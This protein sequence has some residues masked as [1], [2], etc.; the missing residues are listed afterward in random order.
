MFPT[1]TPSKA[2][3]S[4]RPFLLQV[5]MSPTNSTTTATTSTHFVVNIVVMLVFSSTS[6]FF[7][8]TSTPSSVALSVYRT[9]SMY[10][11]KSYFLATVIGPDEWV[12]LLLTCSQPWLSCAIWL[13]ARLSYSTC[14]QCLFSMS[15]KNVSYSESEPKDQISVEPMES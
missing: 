8:S 10:P 1:P 7:P 11:S 2:L 5:S 4:S 9:D 15:K 13:T 3:I 14:H 12:W 6:S